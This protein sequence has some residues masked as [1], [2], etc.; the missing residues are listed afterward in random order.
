MQ[1]SL[2]LGL[3]TLSEAVKSSLTPDAELQKL[4]VKQLHSLQ[5]EILKYEEVNAESR[6]THEINVFLKTQLEAQQQQSS[7]LDEQ[8]KV[9][10]QSELD[11]KARSEQLQRDLYELRAVPPTLHVDTSELEREALHLR[12]Q[13]EK[14]GED[15][16]ALSTRAERLGQE[17]DTCKVDL[18]KLLFIAVVLTNGRLNTKTSKCNCR[19]QFKRPR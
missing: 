2:D 8:I 1:Y 7:R 16:K 4:M 10:K 12:R 11:L 18:I 9:F 14:A 13:L 5:T 19:S 15:L 17:R 3:R 6:K